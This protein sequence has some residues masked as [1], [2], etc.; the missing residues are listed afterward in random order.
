MV[1]DHRTLLLSRFSSSV[2]GMSAF[3]FILIGF[4]VELIIVTNTR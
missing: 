3:P 2:V 4:L 1:I